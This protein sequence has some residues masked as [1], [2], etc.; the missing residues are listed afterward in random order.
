MTLILRDN[1]FR[2]SAIEGGFGAWKAAG[3]PTESKE[4][5]R[6]N[7]VLDVCPECQTAHA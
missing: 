5:E 3:L 6:R 2:A 4:V 7:T 1:G